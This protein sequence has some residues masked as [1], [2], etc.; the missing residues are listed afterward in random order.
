MKELDIWQTRGYLSYIKD[1]V[2]DNRMTKRDILNEIIRVVMTI[3]EEE[4]KVTFNEVK[5]EE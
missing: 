1:L 3:N 2:E 5:E 4:N